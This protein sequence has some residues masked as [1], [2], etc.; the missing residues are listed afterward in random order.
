MKNAEK[1]SDEKNS[2][3]IPDEIL[4]LAE[5]RKNARKQRNFALADEIRDKISALGYEIRETRQGVEIS[6]K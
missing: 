2:Q 1:Y 3:E 4:E 6:K 5:Q